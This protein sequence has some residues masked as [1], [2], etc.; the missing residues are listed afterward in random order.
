MHQLLAEVSI[1]PEARGSNLQERQSHCFHHTDENNA[2]SP[3]NNNLDDSL[4]EVDIPS[5]EWIRESAY[6]ESNGNDD[7]GDGDDEDN[8]AIGQDYDD[9]GDES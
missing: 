4:K 5:S 2:E 9:E 7:S 1:P 3:P 6:L 8:G